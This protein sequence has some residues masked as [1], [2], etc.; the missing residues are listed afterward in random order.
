MLQH[1]YLFFALK[2]NNIWRFLR[3]FGGAIQ[4]GFEEFLMNSFIC[5]NIWDSLAILTGWPYLTSLVLDTVT[6]AIQLCIRSIS[7]A[8]HSSN[9]MG[10]TCS[11]KNQCKCHK[12]LV[13][14]TFRDQWIEYLP[15]SLHIS[16]PLKYLCSAHF[17]NSSYK[18][19]RCDSNESRND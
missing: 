6:L 9:E 7:T 5:I 3:L 1:F 18:T 12:D 4:R 19:D 2:Y 11:V 17:T 8:P 10:R 16:A 14:H 15:S 13:K